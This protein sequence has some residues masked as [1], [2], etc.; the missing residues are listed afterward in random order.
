MANLK[1]DMECD[2]DDED[3]YEPIVLSNVH[4]RDRFSMN[5]KNSMDIPNP[6]NVKLKNI[7]EEP[8]IK[9]EFPPVPLHY[10]GKYR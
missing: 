4:K 7:K 8:D 2:S 6:L 3:V 5:D 1:A 10:P 9:Q